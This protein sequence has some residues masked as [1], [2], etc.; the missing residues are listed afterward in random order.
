MTISGGLSSHGFRAEYI[1]C[2]LFF[3]QP[4]TRIPVALVSCA[5]T[6]SSG[7]S[8]FEHPLEYQKLHQQ[9]LWWLS[10]NKDF[11]YLMNE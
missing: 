1:A 7:L 11:M 9:W 5:L 4:A 8:S 3:W 10:G 6:V 2:L